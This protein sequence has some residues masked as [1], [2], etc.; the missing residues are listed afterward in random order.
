M[1]VI[2]KKR[3]ETP[4]QALGRLREER[5][6]YAHATLS[7]AGRL[8]PMAEGVMLVLVDEENKDRE[9]YLGLDKTYVTEILFGYS[10]DTGDVLG[11]IT[12]S[13][14][15]VKSIKSIK[16]EDIEKAVE[17][18]VGNMSQ[19]YPTY[20]SK[21]FAGEY[22][23]ARMGNIDIH[24]HDVELYSAELLE[25]GEI[26]AQD[27]LE[28]VRG[29]ISHVVGDFRQEEIA[30]LWEESLR[31]SA[32]NFSIAKIRLSASSGFYVRQFAE[33]LGESLSTPALALSIVREKVGEYE[34]KNC[35]L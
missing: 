26:S 35:M 7:Y 3:G 1:I 31:G 4:L 21:S 2:Y 18:M 17:K 15:S 33:D 13:Q 24:V 5:S 23:N 34:I 12:E 30:K 29:E 14:K 22:E 19:K 9:K 8:D 28:R 16:S 20:S 32:K 27:L 10:T 11:R 25:F 6:E